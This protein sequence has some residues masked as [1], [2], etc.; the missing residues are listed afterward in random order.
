VVAES[1]GRA[2][3]SVERARNCP[4]LQGECETPPF[5]PPAPSKQK[6]GHSFKAGQGYITYKTQDM[7]SIAPVAKRHKWRR[8]AGWICRAPAAMRPSVPAHR[9]P[10]CETEIET[11]GQSVDL[12][13]NTIQLPAACMH[14]GTADCLGP[15]PALPPLPSGGG[16]S[17]TH[18]SAVHVHVHRVD[19]STARSTRSRAMRAQC[20]TP[21]HLLPRHNLHCSSLVRRHRRCA[22]V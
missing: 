12:R 15:A 2:V 14:R 7:H 16:V 9:T 4:E 21:W 22:C 1:I 13:V 18:D 3:A 10:G 5:T 19:C 17:A 6:V 8:R 20:G 11:V